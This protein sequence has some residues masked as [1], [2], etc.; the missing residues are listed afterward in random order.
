MTRKK[1]I[2]C[3]AKCEG[4]VNCRIE[5]KETDTL[6]MVHCIE[7]NKRYIFGQYIEPCDN[8]KK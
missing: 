1:Q 4:C 2:I 8:Y 3:S 5:K 6:E 7:R